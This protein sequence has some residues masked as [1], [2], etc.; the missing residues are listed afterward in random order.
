[1]GS[2]PSLNSKFVT[3][4]RIFAPN[5]EIMPCLNLDETLKK[6]HSDSFDLN[7]LCLWH[8]YIHSRFKHHDP[9]VLCQPL[10]SE[11][12]ATTTYL[13]RS[14]ALPAL[15]RTEPGSNNYVHTF[16]SR[17]HRHSRKICFTGCRLEA[18]VEIRIIRWLHQLHRRA[19]QQ[20]P[21]AASRRSL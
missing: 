16:Q 2:E 18:V 8:T 21:S 3:N 20:F 12:I 14:F 13:S 7:L 15:S 9:S 1:M 10:F 19:E 5:E 6:H 4:V 17:L 11:F